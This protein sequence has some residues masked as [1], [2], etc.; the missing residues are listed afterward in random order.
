MEFSLIPGTEGP[1][2][3]QTVSSQFIDDVKNDRRPERV[4]RSTGEPAANTT[5][6]CAKQP[7]APSYNLTT[8]IDQ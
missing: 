4:V 6:K 8:S 1:Q 3:R 5:V 7:V 2:R